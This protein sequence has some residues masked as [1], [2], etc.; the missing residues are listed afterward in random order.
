MYFRKERRGR[1]WVGGWRGGSRVC[2]CVCVCEGVTLRVTLTDKR[3]SKSV[4]RE[5]ASSLLLF[6]QPSRSMLD[7]NLAR[8][9]HTDHEAV[10]LSG[11][12]IF[13]SGRAFVFR[14]GFWTGFVNQRGE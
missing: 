2:V 1:G 5:R 6:P 9:L 7:Y 8:P 14:S 13:I 4:T 10:T 12:F 3:H 11:F